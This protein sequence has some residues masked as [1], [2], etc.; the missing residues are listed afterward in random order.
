MLAQQDD[1]ERTEDDADA[2]IAALEER[3]AELRAAARR[4]DY[5]LVEPELGRVAGTLSIG[6]PTPVPSSL[7]R[8][9]AGLMR[10]L[11]EAE[12]LAEEG[13]DVAR[14][15]EPIVARHFDGDVR[16]C[17]AAPVPFSLAFE[18]TAAA[19]ASP[20]MRRNTEATG[21]RFPVLMGDR[22]IAALDTGTME[23]FRHLVSRRPKTH[24]RGHGR[25]RYETVGKATDQRA[26]ITEADAADEAATKTLRDRD[27]LPEAEKRARL[28]SLLMLRLIMTTVGRHRHALNRIMKTAVERMGAVQRDAVPSYQ[29]L[30]ALIREDV[31]DDGPHM[32]VTRP[33]TR[34]PW[35]QERLQGLSTRPVSAGCASPH[36]RWKPGAC[37]VRDATH[38][39]PLMIMTMDADR[40]GAGPRAARCGP[41]RRCAPL[42]A[43]DGPGPARRDLR[44]RARRASPRLLL[45][46]GLVE[47]VRET[48]GT[49]AWPFP[50]AA[51]RRR[52]ARRHLRQA[53]APSAR[54]A[55]D[56][57]SRRGLL[58]P[59]DD[60]P[61]RALPP[62]RHGR[63]AA[64]HRGPQGRRDRQPA[65]HGS[66]RRRP[67]A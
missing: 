53:P 4:R 45:D 2:R 5:Q 65:P 34:M 1:D 48:A 22:L 16:A 20:D 28:S 44:H 24:G 29:R 9:A 18:K 64:G 63:P 51:R 60:T 50:C 47:W 8:P 56:H 62:R 35:S 21:K 15:A 31:S 59:V 57:G 26:E 33:K 23:E 12:I 58:R 55:R 39:V 38:W 3:I 66:T 13:E 40:G 49:D 25:N 11:A 7:G 36:R 14:A 43:R 17:A 54:Q 67:P 61:D 41:S 46:L 10:E 32:R 52:D 42:G 37:F 27:D 6:L 19:A 30:D